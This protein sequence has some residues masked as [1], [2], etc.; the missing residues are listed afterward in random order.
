MS[1]CLRVHNENMQYTNCLW[2]LYDNMHN[3]SH[4]CAMNRFYT[5]TVNSYL[6]VCVFVIIIFGR[7]FRPNGFRKFV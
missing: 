1:T 5:I 4:L 2:N 7:P 3:F 6:C